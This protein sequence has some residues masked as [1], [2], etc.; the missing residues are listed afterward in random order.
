METDFSIPQIDRIC[1]G[2]KIIQRYTSDT[3]PCAAEHDVFYCGSYETR[4]KMTQEERDLM[5]KYGWHEEYESWA[6]YT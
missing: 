1:L 6:I 2:M 4:D 5:D 3:Y